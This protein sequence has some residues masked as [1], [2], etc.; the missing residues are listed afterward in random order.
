MNERDKRSNDNKGT[1]S[2]RKM[3]SQLN[4]LY[5]AG[6]AVLNGVF[7]KK[8]PPDLLLAEFFRNNRQCGS[9]DR[10]LISGCVYA[11]LR[12]WGYLRHLLPQEW[13]RSVEHGE[14]LFSKRELGV[15]FYAAC[16]CE[17]P[18]SPEL[19]TFAAVY[20]FPPLPRT[21]PKAPF[22]RA[23]KAADILKA[24]CN[25]TQISLLPEWLQER[26]PDPEATAGT[27]AK[28][29]PLWIRIHR[30]QELCLEEFK[31]K[32]LRCLLS[33]KL[34]GAAALYAPR[35]NLFSLEGYAKGRF[36]VQDLASQAIG[37]VCGARPG[38]RILDACAG[39]G[40]K[41]LQLGA[42]M[43]NKG[44]IIAGDIRANKLDEL[45]RR[46]VR[47]GLFN[48]RTRP[49]EGKLWRDFTPCDRVLLDVPCTG[50]GVWRRNPG[51]QW[52]FTAEKLAEH[53]KL[54]KEILENFCTAVKPGGY[55]IYS[56]CSLFAEE[57]EI[58]V[59]EFLERHEEFVL[60][61]GP[62]PLTGKFSDGCYRFNAADG[63]CDYMFAA[64]MEK[65]AR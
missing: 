14:V 13:R 25:I 21:A 20:N 22:M 50:S 2:E 5:T 3:E 57:N 29:P 36:E 54:Q 15:L 56:T 45:R 40:G 58:Q 64:V 1:L 18:D 23:Q 49:H 46:A 62:N 65:S 31:E 44:T 7:G 42:M 9:R 10:A 53:V 12:Y 41:T 32:N 17:K 63:D 51:M 28:R 6:K 35:I 55:L 47:A 43:K 27:L 52:S 59:K 39:A 16:Y 19:H 30:E 34:P 26:I 61:E 8:M 38:E 48:I 33:D 24:E 37:T 4:L 60:K 11:L